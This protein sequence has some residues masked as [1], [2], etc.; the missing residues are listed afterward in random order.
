[1]IAMLRDIHDNAGVSPPGG[2]TALPSPAAPQVAYAPANDGAVG[3][4]VFDPQASGDMVPP[5]AR[6]DDTDRM[7]KSPRSSPGLCVH[8]PGSSVPRGSYQA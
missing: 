6:D 8:C 3:R 7:F 1:M 5:P 2:W 4:F